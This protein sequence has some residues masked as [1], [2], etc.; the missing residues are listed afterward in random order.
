MFYGSVDFND[1]VEEKIGAHPLP[2]ASRQGSAYLSNSLN[3]S[4]SERREALR[5]NGL[6]AIVL[7]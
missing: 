3:R 5:G 2:A 7:L 1:G 6:G 4:G